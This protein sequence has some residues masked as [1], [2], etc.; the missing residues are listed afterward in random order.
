MTAKLE[1]PSLYSV[2]SNALSNICDFCLGTGIIMKGTTKCVQFS[3]YTKSIY[4]LNHNKLKKNNTTYF[5][6]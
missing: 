2:I 1:I 4:N 6:M 5:T 3:V